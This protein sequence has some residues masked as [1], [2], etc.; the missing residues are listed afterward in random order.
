MVLE[1][2]EQDTTQMKFNIDNYMNKNKEPKQ[3]YDNKSTSTKSTQSSNNSGKK[4]SFVGFFK[5]LFKKER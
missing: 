3:A 5:G 4:G 1:K 2:I